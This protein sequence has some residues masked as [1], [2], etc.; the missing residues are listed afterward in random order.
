MPLV[1]GILICNAIRDLMVGELFGMSRG[2]EAALTSFAIGLW[3]SHRF[4]NYL[5]KVCL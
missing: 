1:P 3:C 4:T 2:V 5:R